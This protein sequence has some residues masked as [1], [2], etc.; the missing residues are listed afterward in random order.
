MKV[1]LLFLIFIHVMLNAQIRTKLSGV[2]SFKSSQYA[3]IKFNSTEGINLEDTLYNFKDSIVA[4]VKFMSSL[5]VAAKPLTKLEVGDS[6]YAIINLLSD[7]IGKITVTDTT[8]IFIN[9]NF[10]P[11]KIEQHTKTP[12]GYNLR[13]TLQSFGDLND[14]N[15]TNRLRY[16]VNY[17][18]E[19]FILN[20]LNFKSYFILTTNKNLRTS[21]KERK[22]FLKVYEFSFD[23]SYLEN[24]N[25]K[26]GRSLNPNIISLGSIDGIQ[27]SYKIYQTKFGIFIGSRP[28]YSTYWFNGKLAQA[29]FFVSREDSIKNKSMENTLAFI[30]QTNQLKTDRRFIYFQ[31]RN[32]IFPYSTFFFSSEFDFFLFNKGKVSNKLN[33]NSLTTLLTM[34]PLRQLN[35]SISYDSRKRI[36]YLESFRNSSDTLFENTLRQGLRMSALIRPLNLVFVNLQF[37]IRETPL[38]QKSSLNYG[39]TLGFNHLPIIKSTLSFGFNKLQSPFIRATNYSSYFSKNFFGDLMVNLNFRLYEFYLN[40]GNRLFIERFLELGVYANIFRNLTLSVTF[41]QKLNNE[42]SKFLMIDITNRF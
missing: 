12:K 6:V 15:K 42:K 7:E 37:G 32:N 9:Q 18:S 34:R 29:G 14:F 30:E 25:F 33:L 19:N 3:Y 16:S 23:Y 22:N 26:F 38:D 28:D 17:S 10:I 11:L 8:A 31:H 35:V 4:I 40:A 27:Y 13:M 39:T 2:V 36:Y 20:N 1:I 21:N 41:E 5:S 24:H